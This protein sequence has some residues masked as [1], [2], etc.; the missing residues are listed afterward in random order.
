MLRFEWKDDLDIGY[1]ECF[2]Y[3][4]NNV[5]ND[6]SF[7]DYTCD[8]HQKDDKK[9]RYTRP[10]S[11]EVSWCHGWSMSKGFD[12]DENYDK[13]WDEDALKE[14]GWHIPTGGYQGHCTHTVEDIKKWCENYL[15]QKYI[16]AYYETLAKLQDMK[17]KA[18][19]FESQG[20]VYEKGE[21]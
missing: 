1:Y 5:I 9:C 6:I 10:Y 3:E 8:F 14:K 17:N 15:A 7:I 4:N 16:G 21:K 20:F 13:H 12:Y 19:W 2:L 18:L 11:F